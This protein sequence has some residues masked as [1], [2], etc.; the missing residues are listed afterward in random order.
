MRHYCLTRAAAAVEG[1]GVIVKQ[2]AGPM[3]R[4]GPARLL[5]RRGNGKIVNGCRKTKGCAIR[6][7]VWLTANFS[8]IG[9][10]NPIRF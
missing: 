5:C 1:A 3:R 8:A 9:R 6:V 7:R 2:E 4:K 10:L